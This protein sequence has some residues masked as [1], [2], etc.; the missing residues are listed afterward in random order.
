[1]T[2]ETMGYEEYLFLGEEAAFG[3]V[4]PALSYCLAE[5]YSVKAGPT[6]LDLEEHLGQPDVVDDAPD[7]CPVTGAIKGNAYGLGPVTL[8]QIWTWAYT[9]TTGQLKSL[10]GEWGGAIDPVRH[11][12]LRI[13]DLTIEASAD[14]PIVKWTATVIGRD[15]VPLGAAQAVPDPSP[16]SD[17]S[18]TRA[19][20]P[21]EFQ[22]GA[23]LFLIDAV[24][25]KVAGWKLML[26]NNIDSWYLGDKS[27]GYPEY[28]IITNSK[29]GRRVISGEITLVP[30]T[31]A[32][33]TRVRGRTR[34]TAQIGVRGYKTSV[35]D[36]QGLFNIASCL[37]RGFNPQKAL[38][39]AG[40]LTI[41]FG[42]RKSG[43]T[44]IITAG[45]SD[46]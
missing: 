6:D 43:S 37:P 36:R 25:T 46:V 45:W 26:K 44:A 33:E 27:A 29:P 9:R 2:V 20:G 1:M 38:D 4:A 5:D 8:E 31:N 21:M 14:S 10:T 41:P 7:K 32:F 42:S 19:A 12:G 28:Q 11:L 24:A 40:R 18:V 15:E 22:D 16:Y 13:N 23:S 17:S 3:V 34:W 30:A 35:L 39:K